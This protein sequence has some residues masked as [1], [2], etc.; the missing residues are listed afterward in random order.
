MNQINDL[1]F[2][3]VCYVRN[4]FFETTGMLHD[5]NLE[6]YYQFLEAWNKDSKFWDLTKEAIDSEKHQAYNE[7]QKNNNEQAKSQL[8]QD[9]QEWVIV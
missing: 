3:A 2:N 7:L 8:M 5:K 9:I 4:Q 6:K 1:Q